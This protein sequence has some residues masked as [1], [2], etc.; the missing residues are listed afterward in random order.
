MRFGPLLIRYDADGLRPRP[1]T[2]LQSRWA[3]ELLPALSDGD[4]LELCAGAGQI[5]LVALHAAEQAG[6]AGGGGRRLVQVDEDEDVCGLAERNAESADLAGS[7]AVRRGRPEAVLRPNERFVLVLADPPWVP[8]DRV[9]DHPDDPPSAI[10][11]GPDGLEVVRA[12]LPVVERHLHDSGAA[13]LQVGGPHQVD[14]VRALLEETGSTLRLVGSRLAPGDE[15]GAVAL[16]QHRTGSAT[17]G[18]GGG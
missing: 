10:D 6:A 7:V 5:G 1:W 15:D 17:P 3:A 11:G 18:D 8:S 2:E 16:L 13:L 4:V 14:A 12:L 9:S